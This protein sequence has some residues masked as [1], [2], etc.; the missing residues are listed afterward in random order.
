MANVLYN[1]GMMRKYVRLR[2]WQMALLIVF[3]VGNLWQCNSN[4]PE[5]K[6]QFNPASSSISTE[7]REILLKTTPKIIVIGTGLCENCI[8]VEKTVL[9]FHQAHPELP[10]AWLIYNHYEDRKTFQY[11][12]VTVSPTTFFIDKDNILQTKLI[13]AFNEETYQDTLKSVHFIE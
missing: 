5:I 13:G 8:I 12:E 9:A 3:M 1:H 2:R 10:I 6:R 4:Q 7:V 11:F